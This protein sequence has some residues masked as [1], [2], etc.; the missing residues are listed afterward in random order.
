MTNIQMWPN[1]ALQSQAQ[2]K[3]TDGFIRSPGVLRL[4]G[5]AQQLQ[6]GSTLPAYILYSVSEG[7]FVL[8]KYLMWCIMKPYLPD[9]ITKPN[10]F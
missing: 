3:E 8:L 7:K 10:H 5:A 9:Q 4:S 1:T 2:E 6:Q